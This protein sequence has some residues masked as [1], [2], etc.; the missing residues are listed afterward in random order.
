M[1]P[2]HIASIGFTCADLA[3]T[4]TFFCEGL[5]FHPLGDPLE[6]RGGPYGE[7]LGIGG[8]LIH[9]QRLAIGAEILELTQVV[10]PGAGNRQGRPIPADSRSN[11]GWFQHIC[12][13]VSDL[14]R[15]LE[16]LRSVRPPGASDAI[17]TAPQRLPDWNQAAAGIVAY[18]FRDPEGHPL[19]LLQ[20][21]PDKGD[22]RW[23]SAAA[24][25]PVLGIDHSAIGIADSEASCRFYDGL[26]GMRLGGDGVNHGLEQDDLDGLPGTRV[27]I[28]SHRCP[29]GAGIECLDYREPTGGRPMPPDQGAQD[30][31]HWQVRLQVADLAAVAARA[32]Y[33]GGRDVSAGLVDLGEQAAIIG[34][35]KALQLADP[36]GHHLQLIEA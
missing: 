31:A 20:F 22:P 12:L 3:A 11:D 28:T 23:H 10:D 7:L 24:G 5:G 18:K 25:G 32:P 9:L 2:P 26:L 19:E 13:V 34:G 21:P 27:R 6:L 36:D 4:T 14:E 30:V 35:R 17:S 33:W 16:Q 15:A 1:T 29:E 8:A